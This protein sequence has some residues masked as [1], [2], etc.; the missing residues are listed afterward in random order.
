MAAVTQN[1]IRP[2]ETKHKKTNLAKEEKKTNKLD[3][4]NTKS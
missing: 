2:K 1:Q 4:I 3:K